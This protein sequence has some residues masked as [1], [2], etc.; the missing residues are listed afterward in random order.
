MQLPNEDTGF[1]FSKKFSNR[2]LS[3][4]AFTRRVLA[5][6]ASQQVPLLERIRFA[7]IV[8][9][10]HSE[11]FIK[12]TNNLKK[13][14]KVGLKN[15]FSGRLQA[16]KE[17]EDCRKELRQQ[18]DILEAAVNKE[19]LPALESIGSGISHYNELSASQK[20]E[21]HCYFEKS[22]QPILRPL[23]VNESRSFPFVENLQLNLVTFL[24][25]RKE[26][27]RQVL[28]LKI[29]SGLPRWLEL[30]NGNISVPIEQVIAANLNQVYPS[31][32]FSNI[33]Y[34]RV[35]RGM[36]GQIE[37][38]PE[39]N[40]YSESNSFV[41]QVSA[42]LK[43]RRFA[44]VVRIQ[45]SNGMP[46]SLIKL[47]RKQFKI[48]RK[49][50]YIVNHFL[51]LESLTQLNVKGASKLRFSKH[52][53]VDHPRLAGADFDVSSNFFK[54]INKGDILLHYPYHSF[55]SSVL[56]FLNLAA[57]DPTVL[58]IRMTIYRTSR[59]SDI[60]KTLVLAARQG[61]KVTVLIE[62]TARFDEA[63]NIAWGKFLEKEG[64]QVNYGVRRLK[65]HAKLILVDRKEGKKN[66]QYAHIGTGNYH[67]ETA[68][69][70]ED[71]GIL[72][73]E[74]HLCE[75]ISNLYNVL[76]GG[77]DLNG[78]PL[79]FFNEN[80]QKVLVA[81]ISMRQRLQDLIRREAEQ[82]KL[83][84]PSGIYAKLNQLQDL[85][86]ISEFYSASSVGVPITLNIR[87]LCCL[88]PGIAGLSEGIRVY[89]IV[90]RFLEH[91]RIFRFHNKG[92]PEYYLGS[93]DL[94]KRNLNDRVETVI[95]I[96]DQN[97]K[98]EIDN[99]IS[100]Y[101]ED[102]CSAWDLKPDGQYVVRSPSGDDCSRNA[103][104]IFI[105]QASS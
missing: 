31:L 89:S 68:R 85:E 21:L 50:L 79:K 13:K 103:Q 70:Y 26:G 2:D 104:D 69:L 47:L 95:M 33:H 72:T 39:E 84:R 74:T 83:G 80:Y 32:E 43:L 15:L 18:V 60:I 1:D 96:Q 81:P 61:K 76:A 92:N 37:P 99:I 10:L 44:G 40:F 63:A 41:E 64:V 66:R 6:V 52:Y 58:A 102:N 42:E 27:D 90:N 9:M 11:F 3:W 87:G 54:E 82:A 19:L 12:R 91:S 28:Y 100:V 17:L 30:Q 65:T 7:G 45:V 59:D 97:L 23:V 56:K 24:P 48:K 55:D 51:G 101:E 77:A 71:L 57:L 36:E 73:S 62:I 78:G 22:I 5:M 14:A 105:Q 8:E 53:P 49:E 38:I 35:T 88:C 34:F 93:A 16:K 4:L 67:S 25:E 20:Q 29:P 94:M 98:G 46:A 86:I 75:E